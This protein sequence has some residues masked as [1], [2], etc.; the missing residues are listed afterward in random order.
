M[1]RGIDPDTSILNSMVGCYCKLGELE[2]AKSH[3]DRLIEMN[4]VTC[5]GA[6][7]AFLRELSARNR[8][9]EAFDYFVGINDAGILLG[10]GCY[11]RLI[12]G[13][14]LGGY[15]DEALHVFD[16]MRERGVLCTVHLWKLL[17]HSFCKRG[18]VEEA[19]L[20][21]TEMEPQG[22][23]LDKVMFT[24]FINSGYCKNKRMKWL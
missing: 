9:L 15:L 22:L 13:L 5:K 11:N 12:D 8:F 7:I 18:R 24:N 4:C 23:F 2:E 6:C 20:P 21:S 19:E 10:I 1:S 3:F 14:C 16:I 17:V